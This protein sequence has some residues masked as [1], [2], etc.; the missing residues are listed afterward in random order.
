VAAATFVVLFVG[1][2]VL[3]PGYHR[4]FGL[5]GQVRRHQVLGAD[6]RVA[7][8]C[9]PHRWDSVSFYLQ[10]QDVQAFSPGRRE[11]MIRELEAR[12]LTLLF[13]KSDHSLGEVRAAL[14]PGLEF[15]PCGRQGSVVTAGVV[16]PSPQAA[17]RGLGGEFRLRRA[18]APAPSR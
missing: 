15:V 6:A 9:Y 5:R 12:P 16:R 7:V 3:L 1:V 4:R 8:V 2:Y 14:P 11:E 13:V 10:R 18:E 17:A